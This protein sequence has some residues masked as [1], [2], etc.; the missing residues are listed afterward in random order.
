VKV[1]VIM[2]KISC[3]I[4]AYNEADRIRRVLDVV[5]THPLFDEV[6]VVD[7]GS[8]D[9]TN[10]VLCSYPALRL[11]SYEKNRGK[12]YALSQGIAVSRHELIM[13]LDADLAGL[14]PA[15]LNALA[16]PVLGGHAEVSISLRRN[17]LALY[18]LLGMDFVSG[19][20]VIPKSLLLDALLE[21]ERL[22]RWGGE[23]FMN[24]LIVA[25]K[26]RV[27]VVRW[28]NV[29]NVRKYHKVGVWHGA[30]EEI[31]MIWDVLQLIS[32]LEAVLQT[33][34]LLV[35]TIRSPARARTPSTSPPRPRYH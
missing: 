31:H 14:T 29:S 17:S 26:L 9:E 3:V 5:A 21:M 1:E 19:E 12:T 16:E 13:L 4:C 11:I 34:G 25:R 2:T 6:I 7:D 27:A 18:R 23:V 30:L 22:P 8:T 33:F 28:S 15:N 24:R 35:L 32:P 20:R 10:S